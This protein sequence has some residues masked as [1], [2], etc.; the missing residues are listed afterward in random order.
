MTTSGTAQI[1]FDVNE[2]LQEAWERATGGGDLRSG[3]QLRTARRSL[4]LVLMEMANQGLNLFTIEEIAI[5]LVQGRATYALPVDTVDLI[6]HMLRQNVPTQF[7]RALSRISVSTYATLPNKTVE[8]VPNQV[9]IDRQTAPTITL[10][11]APNG[12]NYVLQAWRLR[13]IQDAATGGNTLDMPFRFVPAIIAG[14]AYHIAMKVP[15]GAGDRTL[16]LKASYN[17]SL[18][19]AKDEDRDR[20]SV[21]LVPGVM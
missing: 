10:Y 20:A 2:I 11:P 4:N 15:E 21:F 14:V 17:E 7:D 6:E 16:L 19:L 3:Y 5:P 13:R 9:Y 1:N 18:Q 8:G 12:P